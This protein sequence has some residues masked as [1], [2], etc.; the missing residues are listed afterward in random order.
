MATEALLKRLRDHED[1][2][3]EELRLRYAP[4]IRYVIAPILGDGRDREE[5]LSDVLLRVWESI[6][7]FDGSRGNFN[8]WLTAIARNTAVDRARR[9]PPQ[10]G[11]LQENF[12]D[13]QGSPEEILIKK[14]QAASLQRALTELGR[15]ELLLFYRKY[16][17]RQ[18]T[19]Q[20][21]AEYGLTERGVEGRLY[22][23]RQKLRKALGG[24]RYDG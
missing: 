15:D 11:E 19:A 7:S 18:S 12:P 3:L 24:E 1:G 8:A 16:Y 21:A 4:R 6:G 5:A 17:Y 13:P 9:T 10:E 23:I 22:R 20:I 2:A 14:E